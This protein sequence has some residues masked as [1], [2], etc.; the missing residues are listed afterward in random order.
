MPPEIYIL[1]LL[2]TFTFALYGALIGTRR[3]FDVFG[4][5][6]V[7]ML[8]AFGG[9]TIREIILGNAPFYFYEMEYILVMFCGFL[10]G[11][12]AYPIFPKIN[13]FALVADA[14]G[15]VTFAYIGAERAAQAGFGWFGIILLATITAVGGGLLRDIAIAETPQIFYRDFYASPAILL[16]IMYVL[17]ITSASSHT[18]TYAILAVAFLLR[19]FAIYFQINLWG[20]WREKA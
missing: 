19:I 20:P 18:A 4:I 5:F 12:L 6:A 7:A 2:G 14:I 10:A 16:G 13:K 3:K 15:L 1:D 17:F 9:G 11:I 8:T